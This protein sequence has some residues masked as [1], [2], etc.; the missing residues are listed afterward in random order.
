MN[1]A[2]LRAAFGALIIP[3]SVAA[4]TVCGVPGA[5]DA[6]V[7]RPTIESTSRVGLARTP[8]PTGTAVADTSTAC[9]L[10][11]PLPNLAATSSI[12]ASALNFD[13]GVDPYSLISTA[14]RFSEDAAKQKLSVSPLKL[15]TNP[16]AW[17][18]WTLALVTGGSSTTLS[19]AFAYDEMAPYASRRQKVID[20]FNSGPELAEFR[21]TEP[22]RG[23]NES[24]SDY[25]K[26]IESGMARVYSRYWMERFRHTNAFTLTGSLQ[27]FSSTISTPVDLDNDGKIDNAHTVRS[28]GASAQWVHRWDFWTAST[29]GANAAKRRVSAVEGTPLRNT[30]GASFSLSHVFFLLDPNYLTSRDYRSKLYVPSLSAGLSADWLECRGTSLECDD[31]LVARWTIMPFLD[32]RL[33]GGAQ[34][35][36]G[37]PVRRDRVGDKK[38]ARIEPVLQLGWSL[39]SL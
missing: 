8:S 37:L 19:S 17:N 2:L 32:T 5:A 28:F 7:A 15:G 25:Q 11:D 35:R 20:A 22:V 18:D 6:T 27:T 1:R 31:R 12:V 9:G 36:L 29:L 13:F 38:G 14:V 4:Q 10:S 26:R 24:L 33:P 3:A 23:A 34:F 30:Y 16:T 39:A 21:R